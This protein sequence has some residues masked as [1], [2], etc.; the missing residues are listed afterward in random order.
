MGQ[1]HLVE[2]SGFID[3][4]T[5]MHFRIALEARGKGRPRAFV[6]KRTGRA[7]AH[8]DKKTLDWAK[9]FEILATAAKRRLV[10]EIEAVRGRPLFVELKLEYQKPKK[11][12]WFCTK[13]IDNDN[14]EKIVWDS[15]Q[16]TFFENDNRIT[17]NFTKKIWAADEPRI[18][19]TIAALKETP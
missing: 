8:T 10:A 1:L 7:D 4:S 2:L 3:E 13:P 19:I 14:A 11:C 16:G 17:D 5:R 18:T 12:S 9:T 6:N 15:L